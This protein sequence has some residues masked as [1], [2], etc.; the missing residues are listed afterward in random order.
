MG[1][2][3]A[4][5]KFFLRKTAWRAHFWKVRDTYILEVVFEMVP[6]FCILH[7]GTAPLLYAMPTDIT[8]RDIRSLDWEER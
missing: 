7:N 1:L 5:C 3:D 6:D 4:I 8:I 2:L